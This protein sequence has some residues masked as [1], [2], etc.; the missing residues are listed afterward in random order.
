MSITTE[1]APT[2]ARAFAEAVAG[3]GC[4]HVFGL[5]GDGNMH[6]FLALRKEGV[7]IVEVRHESAA[8]A[9]AEGYGWSSGRTGICSVTHGPG[10]THVATSLLVAS[11]NRSPLVLIAAETPAGYQGAQTFD[12]ETFV[13][14]CEAVYRRMEPG[15]HPGEVLAEAIALAESARRPVVLGV[16]ADLLTAPMRASSGVRAERPLRTVDDLAAAQRLQELLASA[17]RP[18]LIAGKG[19]FDA[20]ESMRVLADRFGAALATTLPAKGLFDGHELNL[21]ISGGLSHPAAERV[22]READLV[23]AV[24]ASMGRSTTQAGRLFADAHV[25]KVVDEPGKGEFL[26]A[27]AAGTMSRLVELSTGTAKEPWFTPVGPSAECWQED[28]RDYAP[29]IAA[30]TVDPRRA[31]AQISTEI[32]DDAI[33]VISNGH[34]SGFAAAF[35]DAPRNGRFFAA[36][37]F[38]SIGQT[39][40]TAIGVAL[41]APG[42][43]TVV[44]EGDAGFMMHAQELDTAARAGVDLT[45]FILND[46]AL[47]T[48]Y[49]R[50]R[51]E[52]DDAAAA[53]VPPPDLAALAEVFGIRSATIAAENGHA[54][55]R[56]ALAPGL[57]VVDV[58]TSRAVL[59]RHMRLP[60]TK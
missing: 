3:T 30:G 5:M 35:T 59:S 49:Q 55:A 9:M 36:Q 17:S 27:T 16:A 10:L 23:I 57:A 39:L 13:T 44:F 19:A 32:P 8:V 28:L 47:G 15:E 14:S 20:A 50:L 33:V 6:L 45:L 58:R 26:L 46:E 48:E 12:Q 25:V 11:R 24:G 43:K 54:A 31:V 40:T 21:G 18:V 41:G 2:H 42:R 22:L 53:I 29:Q 52:T 34:C 60:G 38:G 56:A 37:G 1:V 4:T 51:E 7:E